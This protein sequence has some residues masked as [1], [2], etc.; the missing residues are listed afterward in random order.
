MGKRQRRLTRDLEAEAVRLVETSGR[1]QK[2]IATD[3]G[4]GLSTLRRWIDKRRE[5]DLEAPP[6]ERQADMVAELKRLRRENEIVRQERE[7]LKRFA[8][9]AVRT[10]GR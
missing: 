7:I 9:G 8:D 3:L 1:T 6:P 4:I 10:L 2:E 5:R